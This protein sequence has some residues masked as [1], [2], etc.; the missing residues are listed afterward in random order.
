MSVLYWASVTSLLGW[1]YAALAAAWPWLFERQAV[2][3]AER[4]PAGYRIGW[5][6]HWQLPAR[7]AA[8]IAVLSSTPLL[9]AIFLAG[10]LRPAVVAVMAAA[11]VAAWI[12]A[13]PGS[14]LVYVPAGAA[15]DK[16]VVTLKHTRS[17]RRAAAVLLVF[18]LI[19]ALA[20]GAVVNA[21]LTR[22]L[23]QAA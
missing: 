16:M 8:V 1:I 5:L 2:K 12:G 11:V 18:G 10:W 6:V 17:I 15:G 14:R 7:S 23:G 19:P 13:P 4:D 3:Q 21:M 22:V 9:A 20:L